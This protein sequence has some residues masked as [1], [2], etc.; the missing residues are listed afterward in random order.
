MQ[1]PLTGYSNIRGRRKQNSF[2]HEKEQG[3]GAKPNSTQS[4]HSY[5]CVH[6]KIQNRQLSGGKQVRSEWHWARQK[7]V[8][9]IRV[10]KMLSIG[11]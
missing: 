11:C 4:R 3:K 1:H 5:S 7:A 9:S 6:T 10:M 8:P 2:E